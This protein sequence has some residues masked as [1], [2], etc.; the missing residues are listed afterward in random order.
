[1]NV[2]RRGN[3]GLE[4]QI[5][6]VLRVGKNAH[7]VFQRR[8]LGIYDRKARAFN[9][10]F[11]GLGLTACVGPCP[12]SFSHGLISVLYS[13]AARV[14]KQLIEIFVLFSMGRIDLN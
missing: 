2:G 12:T 7:Q 11:A 6:V 3:G 8:D 14:F 9:E 10:Q 5:L 1:M 4:A 13:N